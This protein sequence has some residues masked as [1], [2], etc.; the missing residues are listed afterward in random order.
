MREGVARAYPYFSM[1]L[2]SPALRVRGRGGG[3]SNYIRLQLLTENPVKALSRNPLY[4]I[5]NLSPAHLRWVIIN[6]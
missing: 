6:K 4:P 1:F 5:S 3:V 2:P